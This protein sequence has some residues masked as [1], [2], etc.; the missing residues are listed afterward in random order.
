MLMRA[1]GLGHSGPIDIKKEIFN[2]NDQRHLDFIDER[3]QDFSAKRD[4]LLSMDQKMVGAMGVDTFVWLSGFTGGWGPYLAV[5]GYLGIYF[6]AKSAGRDQLQQEFDHALDEVYAI[7][8]WCAAQRPP[9]VV[10]SE[11]KFQELLSAIIPFALDWRELL[12]WDLSRI[13]TDSISERVLEIFEQSPHKLPLMLQRPAVTPPRTN[14][15]VVLRLP[16]PDKW[17]YQSRPYRFFAE[18]AA[19]AKLKWYGHR[20][21]KEATEQPQPRKG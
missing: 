12:P 8:H 6:Y 7:Y 1:L 17:V 15:V 2:P 10:T 20:F 16:E 3:L 4:A 5:A 14:E 18:S 11:A 9:L 21:E 13:H 19:N